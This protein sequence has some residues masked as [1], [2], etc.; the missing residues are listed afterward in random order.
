[1]TE[2]GVASPR[3]CWMRSIAQVFCSGVRNLARS[4][5]STMTNHEMMPRPTVMTP[6]RRK[7]QLRE[8]EVR[9]GSQLDGSGRRGSSA[10]R[11]DAPPSLEAMDA[12][13][14]RHAPADDVGEAG[15]DHGRQVEEGHALGHL[16][17]SVPG[18]D[19]AAR[20]AVHV[21]WMRTIAVRLVER[22][23]QGAAGEE[24]SLRAKKNGRVSRVRSLRRSTA[25]RLAAHLEETEEGAANGELLPVGDER[26][27]EHDGAPGDR[28]GG[29]LVARADLADE[30]VCGQLKD[31]VGDE[32]DA[33]DEAANREARRRQYSAS[34]TRSRRAGR[35][36]S[37][38]RPS[39]SSLCPCRPFVRSR[40]SFG[41]RTST[42]RRSK[43]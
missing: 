19:E 27:A 36:S 21:S 2:S 8:A 17:A 12:V 3:S 4:G 39:A 9:E 28:D 23:V 13:H 5:K 33:G 35:T 7:I 37:A 20:G 29:E 15:E 40:C 18:R 42:K 32:E 38:R 16:E 43:S 14:A 6:N 24:A 1:M 11:R 30:Q 25:G 10:G 31:D 22:N 41:L 26:H 34:W